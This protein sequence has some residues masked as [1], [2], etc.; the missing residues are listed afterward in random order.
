MAKLLISSL[1]A[2]TL[3]TYFHVDFL[4]C[5][6]ANI[7]TVLV[8]WRRN[9]MLSASSRYYLMAMSV[10]D[11]MV[12][13][14][15]VIL[16][17]ILKYHIPEP[18]WYKDP[19]CTIRDFFNYGAYNASIWLVVAFTTERFISI[20]TLQLKAKVCTPRGALYVISSVFLC[21]HI[22][23]IP[24]FWAN[25]SKPDNLTGRMECVYNTVVPSFY[26]EGLVWFQTTLVYII[27]YIIIFTLNGLTLRQIYRS[28]KVYS[29]M[30][31]TSQRYKTASHFRAQKK[32]SAVLLVT[33]SM[34]FAYLCTARFTTQIILRTFFYGINRKDYDRSINIAADIGTMLD[35]TNA[36]VNMYLYA[37]TQSRFRQEV[38]ACAKAVFLPW[39]HYGNRRKHP[40]A[41]FQIDSLQQNPVLGVINGSPKNNVLAPQ[42]E[43]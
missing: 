6:Q 29:D 5:F 2:S 22:C 18:F 40:S 17:L 34:T 37:C 36:A 19:W 26:V 23:A 28:N 1:T 38:L 33:V 12:L 32:K 27:P 11:T 43:D 7:V 21:S 39:K 35:L 4:L 24:Y 10:A 13:I 14:L 31:E 15:I 42:R 9:C 3:Q 16:E 41:V 8:F 25:E 30:R 20:N